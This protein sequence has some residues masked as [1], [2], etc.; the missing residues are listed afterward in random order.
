MSLDS[1]SAGFGSYAAFCVPGLPWVTGSLTPGTGM[2]I[3][4]PYVTHEVQIM[5]HGAGVCG[6][7]FTSSGF[8]TGNFMTIPTNELVTLPVRIANLYMSG[9]T[10]VD[11]FASLSFVSRREMPELSG[12]WAGV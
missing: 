3:E 1:P 5:N 12:S 8:S 6:I 11:V 7:S 9:S 2:K 4:F 10:N